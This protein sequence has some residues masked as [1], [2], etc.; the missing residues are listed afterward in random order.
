M[1]FVRMVSLFPIRVASPS[2]HVVMVRPEGSSVPDH[3]VVLAERAGCAR[4]PDPELMDVSRRSP[5]PGESDEARMHRI[6]KAVRQLLEE[7]DPENFT[8]S[9]R[10]RIMAVRERLN[11]PTVGSPELTR[12]LDMYVTEL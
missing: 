6:N 10:P 8:P 12:A 1:A 2:G 4:A 9:G 5:V 11:D 7:N 3:M